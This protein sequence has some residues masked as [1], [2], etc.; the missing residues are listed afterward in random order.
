MSATIQRWC[1]SGGKVEAKSTSTARTGAEM[2]QVYINRRVV[3]V[4]IV[5]RQ[6][7]WLGLTAARCEAGLLVA[8]GRV[9]YQCI[10]NG[11]VSR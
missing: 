10:D 1:R 6:G 4:V 3:A 5:S 9:R 11:V 7:C 2:L 8:G